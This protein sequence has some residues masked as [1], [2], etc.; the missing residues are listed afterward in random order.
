MFL[1]C[2]SPAVAFSKKIK[3]QSSHLFV[4]LPTFGFLENATFSFDI[5]TAAESRVQAYLVPSDDLT[6]KKLTSRQFLM[7]CQNQTNHV[8]DLNMTN[9]SVGT[10][11]HWTGKVRDMSVYYPI[12]VNCVSNRTVYEVSMKFQNPG[13]LIDFRHEPYPMSYIGTGLL[14][15]VCGLS[16]IVNIM[17]FPQFHIPLQYILAVMPVLKAIVNTF[18]GAFWETRRTTD[19]WDPRIQSVNLSLRCLYT[20]IVLTSSALILSGW[21]TYRDDYGVRERM[22]IILSA[23]VLAHGLMYAASTESIIVTIISLVWIIVGF[24]WYAQLSTGYMIAIVRLLDDDLPE[25]VHLKVVLP[26]RFG[27]LSLCAMG[28]TILMK[29]F[30]AT[31]FEMFPMIE[32]LSFEFGV[33]GLEVV[34]MYTFML[35]SSYA[36]SGGPQPVAQ[37]S[38]CEL[39]QVIGPESSYLAVVG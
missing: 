37:S 18:Q 20:F 5:S 23:A 21:C 16:W 3:V 39:R 30:A 7:V 29:S 33:I 8:S 25:Q 1:L 22:H 4:V 27:I 17:W 34:R 19:D 32:L 31:S 24:M 9:T 10:R 36:G 38:A 6:L 14:H 12:L 26:K 2:V 13:S 11:V 15:A 28:M 35:R